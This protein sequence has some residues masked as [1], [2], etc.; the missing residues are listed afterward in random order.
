MK[1]S[2]SDVTNER[3]LAEFN[4]VVAETE[5]LLESIADAGGAKAVALKASVERSF[6]AAGE[7]LAQIREKAL[8]QACS[9]ARATDKY[10][11]ENPWQTVGIVA[12]LAATTG[13]VAGLLIARR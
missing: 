13:L 10:V 5:Q 12:A 11:Q 2:P 8:G 1:Q 4:T 3:L 9:T 6:A 7:R